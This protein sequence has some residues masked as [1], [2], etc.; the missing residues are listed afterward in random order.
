[1]TTK[2]QSTD[3]PPED[4]TDDELKAAISFHERQAMRLKSEGAKLWRLRLRI[5]RGEPVDRRMLAELHERRASRIPASTAPV[6]DNDAEKEFFEASVAVWREI[7]RLSSLPEGYKGL[8]PD[9]DPRTRERAAWERYRSKLD[10]AAATAAPQSQLRPVG[11]SRHPH[12]THADHERMKETLEA[13]SDYPT[14]EEAEAALQAC[15]T[16]GKE[17]VNDFIE[18]LLKENLEL[19][20]KLATAAPVES[21]EE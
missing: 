10:T 7:D 3:L 17:V 16:S 6:V 12:F 5:G 21:E 15:G 9:T 20:N 19:K 1:M 4:M 2:P 13:L 8:P 18:R 14:E 11:S